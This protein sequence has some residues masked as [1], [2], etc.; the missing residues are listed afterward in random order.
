MVLQNYQLQMINNEISKSDYDGLTD[1]EITDKLNSTQTITNTIPRGTIPVYNATGSSSSKIHIT[2]FIN[3]ITIAELVAAKGDPNGLIL[4]ERVMALEIMGTIIDLTD[5]LVVYGVIAAVNDGWL[6]SETATA[7][8]GFTETL[9]PIY[10]STFEVESIAIQLIY[11]PI[12]LAEVISA[13]GV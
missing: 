9:D 10:R 3:L 11:R 8:T 12:T 13:K 2:N 4:Y 6:T 7:L 1:Q 5:P